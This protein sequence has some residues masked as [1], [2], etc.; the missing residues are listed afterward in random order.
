[1]K[2][3]IDLQR[4]GGVSMKVGS[5]GDLSPITAMIVIGKRMHVVK[6]NSIYEVRLAD[7]I[8][9]QRTN[10]SV[11]NTQQKVLDVGSDSE[12]VGRILLTAHALFS[13]NYLQENIDS[14][15]ALRLSFEILKDVV[16]MG[17]VAQSLE[18]DE[19]DST[20]HPGDDRSVLLPTTRNL[21]H[22]CHEFIQ[23]ADHSLRKLYSIIQVFY[24]KARKSYFDGFYD[25]LVALYGDND[26]FAQ[27]VQDGL[28]F[29][30]FV[31]DIRNSAEHPKKD[32]KIVIKDFS[33]DP[34]GGVV[35]PT[36]EVIH[37]RSP[38]P[39]VNVALL[40]REVNAAIIDVVESMIAGLCNKNLKKDSGFAFEVVEL[41]ETMRREKFVR[42]SYGLVDQNGQVVPSA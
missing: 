31:R 11:P 5:A 20:A 22:R 16:A 36:I 28:P 23:K 2:R 38:Q 27:G 34:T 29:L 25:T 7:D 30:R 18:K 21:T 9:P 6:S 13:K 10:P 26:P 33:F 1:M 3:P 4:D 40:V 41:P 37:S 42:Y 24:P 17:E 32:Q 35:G 14:D 19:H 12:P 39:A 15:E 8:D